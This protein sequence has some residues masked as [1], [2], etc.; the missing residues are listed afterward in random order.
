MPTTRPVSCSHGVSFCDFSR[1]QRFGRALTDFCSVPS[2]PGRY[3]AVSVMPDQSAKRARL[4][5]WRGGGWDGLGGAHFSR[6]RA[7]Q[8]AGQ[9]AGAGLAPAW[10]DGSRMFLRH[11]TGSTR[12]E[13]EIMLGICQNRGDLPRA[14]LPACPECLLTSGELLSHRDAWTVGKPRSVHTHLPLVSSV[15]PPR[16]ALH[17][18]TLELGLSSASAMTSEPRNAPCR[19]RAVAQ[20]TRVRMDSC[21]VCVQPTHP[22]RVAQTRPTRDAHGSKSKAPA[23]SALARA[24]RSPAPPREPPVKPSAT[25]KPIVPKPVTKPKLLLNVHLPRVPPSSR[26]SVDDRDLEGMTEDAIDIVLL[27]QSQG[28]WDSPDIESR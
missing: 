20:T 17:P 9:V 12:G 24:A 2:I 5:Q 25:S 27:Q 8:L 14:A 1:D 16:R 23:P 10:P 19:Q 4:R 18:D 26:V 21:L 28:T 15:P 7:G 22:S 11:K 3:G 6:G 13:R